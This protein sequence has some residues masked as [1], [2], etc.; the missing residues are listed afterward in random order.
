MNLHTID[1]NILD[2]QG[3]PLDLRINKMLSDINRLYQRGQVILLTKFADLGLADTEATMANVFAR[4]PNNTIFMTEVYRG[5]HTNFDMPTLI[6]GARLSGRL[7]VYGSSE[8]SN[9]LT[10]YFQQETGL[11]TRHLNKGAATNYT[12]TGWHKIEVHGL[13]EDLTTSSVTNLENKLSNLKTPGIYYIAGSIMSQ[14]T[15]V[16]TTGSGAS[17]CEVTYIHHLADT[18]Q[19][20]RTNGVAQTGWR[21]QISNNGTVGEWKQEFVSGSPMNSSSTI[22]FAGGTVSGT[23]TT[24]TL[25]PE[26][27]ATHNIGYASA[28]YNQAYFQNA[29]TVVS[30]VNYKLFI[31]D[32]PDDVLDAWSTVNYYQWKMKTAVAEKG[33]EKARLHVGVLAQE[34]KEKFEAAGLDATKYGILIYDCWE[35]V[36]AV[37]YKPAV[38]DPDTNELISEEVQA[39]EGREAGE[40]WMVRMEECLALEAA[41]MRRT[42]KRLEDR[43]AALEGK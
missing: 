23:L 43:M 17:L 34:I 8:S 19:T 33:E 7:I 12:D 26:K 22:S 41:L 15:D 40:I 31:D 20:L 16:P 11:W 28:A 37:E 2:M 18:I 32:I 42:T 35:A 9:K 25:Q 6:N 21:R 30:D 4:M 1:A 29:P 24:R 3:L 27:T 36:E 39:V 14:F 38:Y 10:A 13:Q 5:V